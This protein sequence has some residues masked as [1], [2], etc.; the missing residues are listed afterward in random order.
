MQSVNDRQASKE[1]FEFQKRL[2]DAVRATKLEESKLPKDDGKPVNWREAW[3]AGVL[4]KNAEND[5]KRIKPSE[6]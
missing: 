4:K 3:K 2:D 5:E 1:K 6:R